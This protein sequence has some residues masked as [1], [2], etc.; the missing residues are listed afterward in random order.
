MLAR[1]ELADANGG[2]LRARGL[3][4][5]EAGVLQVL[6]GIDAGSAGGLDGGRE[7]Y[8][9]AG[10]GLGVEEALAGVLEEAVEARAAAVFAEGD[11]ALDEEVGA[12][13][14]HDVADLERRRRA[15]NRRH[16]ALLFGG[17]RVA[18]VATRLVPQRVRREADA[19]D[20]AE[21][22]KLH[23]G[24]TVAS[25]ALAALSAC[26]LVAC[27]RAAEPLRVAAA[28]DVQLGAALGASPFADATL[29]GGDVRL[30]NLEGPLTSAPAAGER[31]AFDPAR[32][33]WL[34]DRVD[35]VSLANN[36]ALDQ[37]ARGRDDTVRALAGA[38]VAAAYDGHDATLERRGRRVSVL[39]RAFAPDA[40]LDGADAASLVAAVARASR[41]TIVSLH[42]GHTGMLLPGDDQKRLAHRLVDAGAVAVVGHGPH[43]MQGAERYGR[44]VIAYSLGNFAFGCDCTDVTDAYVLRFTVDGDGTARDITLTPIVAGLSRPPARAHD[45]DLRAQL[46][47][48]CRDLS[49]GVTVE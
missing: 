13:V 35:V 24:W 26:A 38:G 28:G 16:Q 6:G 9:V 3:A 15:L 48:L 37:G 5:G 8:R 47:D 21:H 36:H 45:L 30:V 41:P 39:A 22:E 7:Q 25:F 49:S 17:E 12:E 2:G 43:T 33:A 20:Q 32:A 34:R 31:F 27:H 11:D 46:A 4:I 42:W 1:A 10:A 19:C 44:G 29:L 18:F 14:L 23:R 40:D